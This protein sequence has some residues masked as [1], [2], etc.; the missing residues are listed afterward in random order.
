M[1]KPRAPAVIMIST[2]N[3]KRRLQDCTLAKVLIDSTFT[4]VG[5]FRVPMEPLVHHPW[6][7]VRTRVPAVKRSRRADGSMYNARRMD[8][9]ASQCHDS[10]LVSIKQVF[11]G[12]VPVSC[13]HRWVSGTCSCSVMQV[14]V[15]C[16]LPRN[17]SAH[18][19]M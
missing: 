13:R 1:L 11:I 9:F 2:R 10:I 17:I 18:I 15:T 7:H 4:D 6:I 16:N 12:R 19:R 3:G 8:F 5:E 14:S